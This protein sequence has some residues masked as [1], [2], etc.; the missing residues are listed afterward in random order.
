LAFQRSDAP[1]PRWPD[2]AYPQQ[3]HLDLFTDDVSGAREQAGAVGGELLQAGPDHHVYADPAG[4][5]F[6]I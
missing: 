2:S 3:V 4:H 5:P 6:C 1:A